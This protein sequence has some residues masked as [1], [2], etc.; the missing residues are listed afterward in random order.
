MSEPQPLRLTLT[1]GVRAH[2]GDAALDLRSASVRR[3]LAILALSPDMREARGRLAA[4]IWDQSDEAR[5]RQNLRQALHDLGR[6]LA[7]AGWQGL[8][9]DRSTVALIPGSVVS[10]VE[11]TCRAVETGH[12]PDAL[13]A[14]KVNPQDL[15]GDEAPAG[16]MFASWLRLRQRD[17]ETRLQQGLYTILKTGGGDTARQAA[18]ALLRL[19]PSDEHAAR[20][21][22][23]AC[24]DAGQT[25]RALSVYEALWTHLDEA[26]DCE[27]AAETQALIA[28]VKLDERAERPAGRVG[29]QDR[30][31]L[32]LP[33][34]PATGDAASD[35]SARLFRADLIAML[36]RFRMLD[37]VDLAVSDA[38]VDF[39]L[40]LSV[41]S[42]AGHI[43]LIA[44]LTRDG[45]GSV[46]W[47]DRW[48]RL[49]EGWITTQAAVCERLA[50]SL[51]ETISRARLAGLTGAEI[52]PGALD[53][54]LLGNMALDRFDAAGLAEAET[55][56]RRLIREAPGASVGYSSLARLSNG[57]HLMVPGRFRRAEDHAEARALAARAVALDPLDS[58]AHLHRAWACAL[59][60]EHDSAAASFAMARDCNPAD[61]WTVLSSALG[62]GFGGDRALAADLSG[63]VLKEG[64]TTQAFQWGF[65]APIRFLAGDYAGCV[66]AASDGGTAI[67]NL[68]A[69]KA[70]A[71][72][73]ADEH[74]AARSAW[75]GFT[76][77]CK[78]HW[79]GPG[80]PLDWFLSLF[81]IRRP[82]DRARLAEGAR[83]ASGTL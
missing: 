15:L 70:A 11:Q 18:E 43:L 78:P 13:L 62:A 21:L 76:G 9:A 47:S 29:A 39:R 26:F 49:K 19:D 74:A 28:F 73:H 48:L 14:G 10:D 72:W 8:E 32:G 5:A 6:R 45:D 50:G 77:L 51:A 56:F 36:L 2:L 67:P 59:L 57:A 53:D 17:L 81:P 58:R 44:S 80:T 68:P 30:L 64:W 34:P 83:G 55:R 7:G 16:E 82:D 61:P 12:V 46:I 54:W 22:I 75:Q 3:I 25:G 42:D 63:R 35:A 4:T 23:K 1:G 52:A 27:P 41:A 79:R 40:D 31:R 60:G 71:L 65:H 69:W 66:Q 37:I 20:F 24:H 38:A 33:A